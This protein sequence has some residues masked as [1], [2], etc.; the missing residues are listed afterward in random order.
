NRVKVWDAQTGKEVLTLV[1]HANM[2]RSGKVWEAQSVQEVH[3]LPGHTGSV[4]RVSFSTDGSR[5]IAGNGNGEVHA[6]D[7]L[8]GQ[9][10][11]PCT[12]PPPPPQPLAVSPDG[13][14]LVHIVNGQAV[15][16]PRVL[17]ADDWFNQRL[18]DQ[19]RTHFWHLRMARLARQAKDAFALRF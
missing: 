1:G 14:R 18:Q 5:V 2:V 3:L 7:A 10:I 15:I 8:T 16:Q 11:L 4:T 17:R 19:A 9:P 12:A 6:W 13:K